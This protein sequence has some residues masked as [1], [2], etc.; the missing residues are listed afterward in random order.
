MVAKRKLIDISDEQIE[1]IYDSGK[2]ATVSFIRT[3]VD[4]INEL[5]ET[6]ERQQEEIN[7]LKKII[8]KD[9]HNSNKPPSSDNPYKKQTKSLRK[10]GG[11]I[12]GQKN[13]KGT[14]LKAV[15]NPDKIEKLKLEKNCG[16][17]RKLTSGKLLGF[18]NRQVIDLPEIKIET[19]EY[20]AEIIKCECGCIHIADFPFGIKSKVQYGSNLKAMIVYL[21]YYGFMS[22]ER[23]S[24][25]INDVL[26][27]KI[28]QGTLVNMIN[29]SAN[30]LSSCVNQI[31][32]ALV[33]EKVVHFDET[34]IRI[35]GSLHWLHSAGNN[36]YTFYFPHEKRG[37]QAMDAM[38]ILPYF[39]GIAVHDHWDS[40]Y[41]YIQC[42]HSLCNSHHLREL[43]FFEE[44]NAEWA[45]KIK[46]CLLDAKKEKDKKKRFTKKRKEYYRRK[47]YRLLNEGLK[48]HPKKE[49]LKKKRG[50][51]KQS[52]AHNL[53]I[54][55]K[56]RI[57]DVLC[58]IYNPIVP[59][60]NNLSERDIRMAKVQQK[61]SGTF[62]SYKGAISFCIIRSYM[63]TAR[64]QGISVFKAIYSGLQN[65]SVLSYNYAE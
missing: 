18:E 55:M 19:T 21:K 41:Q 34:G 15:E 48:I 3:L 29:E 25:F 51:I 11:K 47:M 16:C 61:V 60:D 28:S 43:I 46:S 4:K 64:K 23:I 65:C 14:N 63:S 10:K 30:K 2:E 1:S 12:G 52:K 22:Y 57:D 6:V 32:K 53:L 13:H 59:F 35:E 7:N 36:N 49:R 27:Q 8:S 20:Q 9:S 45:N 58:F 54:R 38:N 44:Q 24:E 50:R 39:K 17:G 37:K 31:K 5:A 56:R 26:G 40:Y 42:I 62:R 33:N